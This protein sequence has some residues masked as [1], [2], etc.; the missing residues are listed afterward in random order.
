MKDEDQSATAFA[1]TPTPPTTKMLK[2][3]SSETGISSRNHYKFWVLAAIILLALWSMF[4]GSV[5]LKW[6]AGNL[7]HFSDDFDSRILDDLDVLE[8]EE[9][10]KVVKKMWD[11]YTQS[12]TIWLPRFWS[13][14][15]QAAYEHLVS[16]IPGVRD[17][18]VSEIA[19]LSLRLRSFSLDQIQPQS[20][21]SRRSRKMKLAENGAVRGDG[22][23][24]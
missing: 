4:T 13:E 18:A 10:E 3:E 12:S 24:R 6:S 8:V 20:E 9:R 21:K 2:R 19:K 22:S 1:A 17:A 11:V 7:T 15:F 16:D 23:N 5:T 14:A